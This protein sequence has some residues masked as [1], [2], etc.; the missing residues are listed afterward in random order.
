MLEFYKMM[1]MT[2]VK[3]QIINFQLKDLVTL[4]RLAFVISSE[5]ETNVLPIIAIPSNSKWK[6][7]VSVLYGL[8][9]SKQI[10]LN[11][12]VLSDEEPKNFVRINDA[13]KEEVELRNDLKEPVGAYIPIIRVSDFPSFLI[14]GGYQ[15]K[16]PDL[17]YEVIVEKFSEKQ[18]IYALKSKTLSDLIRITI[19]QNNRISAIFYMPQSELWFTIAGEYELGDETK[20]FIHYWRGKMNLTGNYVTIDDHGN[21]IFHLGKLEP[22]YSYAAFIPIKKVEPDRFLEVFS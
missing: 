22:L 14:E 12:F 16:W 17:D 18:L 7:L 19:E 21:P 2:T 4:V 3:Y 13:P 11:F 9:R 1:R 6:Y 15:K 5:L 8:R 10:L 20:L